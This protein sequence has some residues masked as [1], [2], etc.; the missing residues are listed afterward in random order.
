VIDYVEDDE[1]VSG[2][3]LDAPL[4]FSGVVSSPF[5]AA[6]GWVTRGE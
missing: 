1:L 6:P 5:D 3:D 4:A 2:D